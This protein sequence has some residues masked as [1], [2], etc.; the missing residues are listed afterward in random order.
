MITENENGIASSL[1]LLP[2]LFHYTII[3]VAVDGPL[4]RSAE[5][6][7]LAQFPQAGIY[8][9]SLPISFLSFWR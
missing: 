3:P 5:S 9:T 6:G 2:S 1:S 8:P 4:N 7:K